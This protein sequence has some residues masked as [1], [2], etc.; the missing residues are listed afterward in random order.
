MKPT[1]T[2]KIDKLTKTL[3]TGFVDPHK[4]GEFKRAMIDAQLAREEAQ[5]KPLGKKDKE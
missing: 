1:S 4:R 2:F 3:M 5:R